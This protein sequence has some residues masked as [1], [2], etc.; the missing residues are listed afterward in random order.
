MKTHYVSLQRVII[1]SSAANYVNVGKK[2][3]EAIKKRRYFKE[4]VVLHPGMVNSIYSCV[5]TDATAT[6]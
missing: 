1:E 6:A 2:N 5:T 3:R 4:H